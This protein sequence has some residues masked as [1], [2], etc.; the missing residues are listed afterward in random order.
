[1]ILYHYSVD[2]YH[3]DESLIPDYNGLYRFAEPYL[4]ALGKSEECFFSVYYSAMAL[5]RELCALG[6][7]KHENYIK[8]AVEGIF[9]Y[10]RRHE[11]AECSVSRLHC[12]Y[13]CRTIEEA[14]SYLKEDC[15]DNKDFSADA[16]SLLEVEA[17]EDRLYCYDQA[18]FDEAEKIMEETADLKRVFDCARAY[19]SKTT[20][21]HP[22]WLSDGENHVLKKL[23]LKELLSK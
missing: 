20:A 3:G 10:I 18:I 4:L 9:E 22:E 19:F 5:S 8:D 21:L 2:S 11:F 6:L 17:A 12:V 23:P 14:L 16:V 13:Y 15:L 1:M 7:R